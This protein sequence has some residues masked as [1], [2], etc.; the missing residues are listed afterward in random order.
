MGA[1][2]GKL[3]PAARGQLAQFAPQADDLLPRFCG[4]AADIGPG[5]DHGL[6]HLGLD[7]L[8]HDHL[9][10]AENL[11]DMRAQFP[12]LGIHDL[13]FL[14]NAKGEDVVFLHAW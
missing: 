12:R 14:L 7:P 4:C 13:E 5:L 9:P 1:G 8:L 6:M 11:L 10:V 3:R 2:G